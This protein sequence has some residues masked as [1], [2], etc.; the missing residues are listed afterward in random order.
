MSLSSESGPEPSSASKTP[1]ENAEQLPDAQTSA[2][3]PIPVGPLRNQ[4]TLP[5]EEPRRPSIWRRITMRKRAADS[6]GALG[7]ATTA[8]RLGAIEQQLEQLDTTLRERLE[9]LDGRLAEVWQSEE[10]LSLLADI[11]DKLDR[12]AENQAQLA[13]SVANLR[14]TLG[15]LAA[16]VVVAAAA[17]GFALSQLL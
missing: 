8:S 2:A 15:W 5:R 4:L 17:A 9:A 10:Q 14:R 7:A 16:L 3:L 6:A 1:H 11:Q 13:G 12:L